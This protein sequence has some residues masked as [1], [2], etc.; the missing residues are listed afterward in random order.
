ML[1]AVD[2]RA[3]PCRT[4]F[5]LPR[6]SAKRSWKSLGVAHAPRHRRQPHWKPKGV[7]SPRGTAERAGAVSF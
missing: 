7:K 5:Y 3:S 4:K 6:V 1:S 2:S